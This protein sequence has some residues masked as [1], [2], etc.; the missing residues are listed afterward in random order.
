MVSVPHSPIGGPA[1][2]VT[3][4]STYGQ[5]VTGA[6][7]MAVSAGWTQVILTDN[8]TTPGRYDIRTG[9]PAASCLAVRSQPLL[10]WVDCSI[11]FCQVDPDVFNLITGATVI[12]DGAGQSVG[13]AGDTN[14]YADGS[15]AVEVWT[16]LARQARCTSGLPNYGYLL[17]PWMYGAVHGPVTHN[18]GTVSFRLSGSTTAGHQWGT[19]PYNVVLN[20]TGVP[21]PLL[22]PIPAQRHRHWQLTAVPPPAAAAGCQTV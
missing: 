20:G 4:I 1:V 12:V 21:S 18:V 2:R 22:T 17:L 14:T 16:R 15:V 3:R 6:C 13:F 5:V 9:G 19:G 10:N 7:Q 8:V 11:D